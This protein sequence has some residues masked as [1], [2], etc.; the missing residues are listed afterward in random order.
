MGHPNPVVWNSTMDF[1]IVKELLSNLL[2]V[3][4]EFGLDDTRVALWRSILS[5]MPD[6]MVNGD[7][8]LREWM[9]ERLDDFYMHRH[10]SHLY[11]LFPGMR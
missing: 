5:D 4:D 2:S 7:G 3:S 10:L 6:Y 9:D 8:A 11:P 1:A